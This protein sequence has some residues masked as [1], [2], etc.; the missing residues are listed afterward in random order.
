MTF[1]PV[2]PRV[3][4]ALAALLFIAG[5]TGAATVEGGS[6]GQTVTT[7]DG[8]ATTTTSAGGG[9]GA[10]VDATATTTAVPGQAAAGG[11]T[12]TTA[13]VVAPTTTAKPQAAAGDPG[14]PVSPKLGTYRYKT[15]S[16]GEQ[17]ETTVKIAKDTEQVPGEDRFVIK[18]G[19][20]GNEQVVYTARRSDG[21]YV[22]KMTFPAPTGGSIDC[23]WDPDLLDMKFP[24]KAGAQWNAESSCTTTFNGEKATF[25]MVSSSR[26]AGAQRTRIGGQDIDVWG[27][28]ATSTLTVDTSY[29]GRPIHIVYDSKGTEQYSAR[30]GVTVRSDTQN[31]V[32]G[33]GGE[34]KSTVQRE[35]QSLTPQ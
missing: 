7:A 1:P 22:R 17:K 34:Q 13:K 6:D 8:A 30:N 2:L 33:F 4:A 29:Q 18:I 31:T 28:E 32:T 24:L 35:L 26:V 5:V 27:L 10:P 16:D 15:T 11:G 19:E 14:Q 3:L 9:L 25:H 20:D 23:D 21:I 12:T